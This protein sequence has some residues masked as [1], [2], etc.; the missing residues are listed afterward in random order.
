MDEKRAEPITSSAPASEGTPATPPARP[1]P[2]A[3]ADWP[4]CW[5]AVQ[6]E[7]DRARAN[8]SEALETFNETH[9]DGH[10]RLRR[11]LQGLATR[12]EANYRYFDDMNTIAR[13][14]LATLEV[15]A[16]RPVDATNLVLST[17]SIV[18]L[19][20]GI[21]VIAASYWNLS[22]KLD[23][24]ER[25]R[26]LQIAQIQKSIE[27]TSKAYELLR[28]DLQALQQSVITGKGKGTP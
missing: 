21:L 8:W 14:K 15:Q 18:A 28:L 26:D 10:E 13:A 23:A 1:V 11:D 20:G 5:E 4:Q 17:R 7:V 3:P 25:L 2:P 19:V 6:R 16:A 9:R 27:Q 24:Q 22:S 12:V